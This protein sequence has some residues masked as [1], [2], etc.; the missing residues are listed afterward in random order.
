MRGKSRGQEHRLDTLDRAL[1]TARVVRVGAD[2]LD[3]RRPDR[4]IDG[5]LQQGADGHGLIG[6]LGEHCSAYMPRYI[7]HQK[8]RSIPR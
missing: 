5:F 3:I 4:Q 6:K 1:Q 2:R 7:R 8:H